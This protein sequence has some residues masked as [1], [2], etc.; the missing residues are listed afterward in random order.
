MHTR[1]LSLLLPLLA[2]VFLG[3]LAAD[4]VRAEEAKEFAARHILIGFQGAKVP[5][6]R[7]EA[8]AKDLADKVRAEAAAPGADFASLAQKHSDD[9]VTGTVGG[10]LGIFKPGTMTPLFQQA[11]EKL[12]DGEVSGVVKTEFGFHIIQRISLADARKVMEGSTTAFI[13]AVFPYKGGRDPRVVRSKDL[14]LEDAKRAVA[15]LR[16]GGTFES[17]PPEWGATP[18]KPMWMP[19]VLPK[20][21]IRPELK[22]IEEVAFAT[23]VGDVSEPFDTQLGYM[24][25]KRVPWFRSHLQHFLVMWKGSER[26]PENVTRTKEE[27]RLRAE[28]AWKKLEAD[29]TQWAKIVAEYSDEPGAGTREGGA[30][31][32]D[33]VEPGTMI[34]EFD[35]QVSTLASGAHTGVFETRFGYHVVRRV[36]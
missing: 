4:P 34:P 5:A 27:A 33:I 36:D 10:F 32:L 15:Y 17:M 6:G 1:T 11:V 8:D 7:S 14:A 3:A 25:V 16:K 22:P 28:E 21:K 18:I 24:V 31:D 12:Q 9:K 30:G 13:G 23:P 26:S 19:L 2:V 29:P 35:A 20:G